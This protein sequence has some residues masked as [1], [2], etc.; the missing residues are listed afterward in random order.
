MP[1]TETKPNLT[2]LTVDLLGAFV[3]NNNVRAE[4]LPKLIAETHA[5]LAA[6]DA[7]APAP[8]EEAAP[9]FQ[10]AVSV[11]KSLGSRDHIISMIDG[12]PYRSLKRHL[13]ANG[14]TPDE[15]RQRY[16]L[17]A[18]YPMVAPGYSEQRREVAKRL[19]LGRK[20]RA[21]APNNAGPES[22]GGAPKRRGRSPAAAK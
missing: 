6:I 12:K 10:P 5:A 21:A 4:D 20:P 7:P 2:E 22:G 8:D 15:Y 19:G 11:R 1:D 17:P 9:E 13:S 3:S 16:R 18:S 14:L